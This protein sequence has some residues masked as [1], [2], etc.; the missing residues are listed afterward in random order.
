MKKADLP[1]VRSGGVLYA[2]VR[3]VLSLPGEQLKMTIVFRIF[4]YVVCFSITKPITIACD[5]LTADV[6]V[7]PLT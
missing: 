3:A 2:G 1:V 7:Q 6:E 5:R 4:G